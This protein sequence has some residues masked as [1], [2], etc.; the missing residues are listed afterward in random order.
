MR[1]R[2]YQLECSVGGGVLFD[3]KLEF[4]F[5]R[6]EILLLYLKQILCSKVLEFERRTS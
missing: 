2:I 1:Q 6:N 4:D 5:D 3:I